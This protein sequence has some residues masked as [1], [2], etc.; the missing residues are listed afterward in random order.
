MFRLECNST[1]DEC[2]IRNAFL[3]ISQGNW[4]LFENFNQLNSKSLKYFIEIS[5]KIY[6]T[7]LNK[8]S[9]FEYFNEKYQLTDLKEIQ[10]FTNISHQTTIDYSHLSSDIQLDQR[11]VCLTKP[12]Y[13][14]V[15]ISNLIYQGFQH[16]QQLANRFVN[17]ILYTIQYSL[18]ENISS[19]GNNIIL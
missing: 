4:L 12:D 2:Q 5:S 6:E 16:A 14:H 10:Y 17:Y 7:I 9:T 13:N 11:I 18:T 15:F 3:G 19:H 8:N 1:I